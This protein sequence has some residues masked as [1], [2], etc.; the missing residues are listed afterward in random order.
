MALEKLYVFRVYVSIWICISSMCLRNFHLLFH[1]KL[2]LFV[3]LVSFLKIDEKW[4]SIS[5][6]H[7]SDS[8]YK[9]TM[10]NEFIPFWREHLSWVSHF[11]H[12]HIHFFLHY[13]KGDTSFVT[14]CKFYSN[15]RDTRWVFLVVRR[16]WLWLCLVS[17]ALKL[18]ITNNPIRKNSVFGHFSRSVD[19]DFYS[20]DRYSP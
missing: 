12:S 2:R 10:F 6:R 20:N 9:K 3:Y 8:I 5:V 18:Q 15:F 17:R 14:F 7:F 13:I 16:K 4:T 19:L 11:P 1:K